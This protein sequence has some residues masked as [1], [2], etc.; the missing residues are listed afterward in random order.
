MNTLAGLMGLRIQAANVTLG[1][2]GDYTAEMFAADYPQFTTAEEGGTVVSLVPPSMLEVFISMANAAIQPER[3]FEQWRL[4]AGLFTAHYAS[5]YLQSYAPASADNNT[6]SAAAS[7]SMT[8]SPSSATLGDA[9]VTYDT[10]EIAAATEKYGA[11]NATAYGMQL[12][13]MAKLIAIGGMYVI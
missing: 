8:G 4:A 1:N 2:S 3:W 7:G 5:L 6:Y 10:K 9:S 11:W 13:T 12:A